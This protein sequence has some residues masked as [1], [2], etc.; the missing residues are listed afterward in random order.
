MVF[1][2]ADTTDSDGNKVVLTDDEKAALLA[3]AQ[4]VRDAA[5][6][7]KS[8]ED[9]VKDV[10]DTK[11]VSSTSYGDN[12]ESYTLDEAI[13]N[14]ADKLKDGEVADEV[15]TTDAG[16]YVIQMKATYDPDA[17]ASKKERIINERKS[18]KFSEVYDAWQSAADYTQDDALLKEITFND[19]YQMATEAQ[20]ETGTESTESTE[21]AGSTEATEAASETESAA[22][23]K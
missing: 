20:S 8:M 12:D 15:I 21:D 17:T 7:G 13:R 1:S 23:T 22:A 10:D 4:K 19:I 9:A 14:A 6:S 16:Y 11:T 2:T 5:A 3:N 18:S